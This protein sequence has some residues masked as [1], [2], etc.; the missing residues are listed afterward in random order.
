MIGD[1]SAI[2]IMTDQCTVNL[3]AGGRRGGGARPPFHDEYLLGVN[4]KS[5]FQ[6]QA[7]VRRERKRGRKRKRKVTG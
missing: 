1:R 7:K 5:A 3:Y 2:F 4:A 6:V